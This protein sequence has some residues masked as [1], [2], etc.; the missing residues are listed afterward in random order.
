M[1]GAP[2]LERTVEL[3]L[4]GLDRRAVEAQLARIDAQHSNILEGIDP[5]MEWPDES[6]WHSL[7]ERDHLHE[8]A[9]EPVAGDGSTSQYRITVP[10]PGVVRIRLRSIES[11][12]KEGSR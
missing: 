1:D 3:T 12:Q 6:Q 10:M 9:I 7:R 4:T 8:E 2:I 11:P 5:G